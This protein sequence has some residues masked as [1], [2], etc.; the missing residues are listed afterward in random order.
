MSL[1]SDKLEVVEKRNRT[2]SLGEIISDELHNV[3]REIE[4]EYKINIQPIIEQAIEEPKEDSDIHSETTNE[5]K[6]QGVKSDDDIIG[7]NVGTVTRI[8]TNLSCNIG[9]IASCV[10][11]DCVDKSCIPIMFKIITYLFILALIYILIGGAEEIPHF[12]IEM[13]DK[14]NK[15]E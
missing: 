10:S 15:N 9:H 11:R 13:I 8:C 3:N 14:L 5:K 7:H 12:I 2:F 1:E 4:N 6:N